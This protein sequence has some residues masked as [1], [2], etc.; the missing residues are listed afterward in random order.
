VRR[1]ARELL[2]LGEVAVALVLLVGAG[3]VIRTL[4]RLEDV[5]PGFAADR[6]VAMEVALPT[7][8]YPE[9]SQVPFYARLERRV[10]ALPGVVEVGA[11]N[12]L[13]LSDNYDSRGVQIEDAPQ[14]VGR[15]PSIQARSVTPGYFAAMG[16]PLLRGRLFDHTDRDD[17]RL[18][19]VVS[20]SMAV[21][22]W[23]DRDPIG[24]RVTFNAGVAD[25]GRQDVGGAGSREV[26]GVVGD[27]KHLALD[28]PAVPVFYTP[29]SQQPSYHTMTLVVRTAVE[30]D[31]LSRSLRAAL[32]EMDRDVP[33]SRPRTLEQIV[34]TSIAGPRVRAVLLGIFAGLALVL[35]SV[36]VY[37]VVGCLVV[38]RTH[39]IGIR[40]ALGAPTRRVLGLLV[41]DGMRPVCL[42]IVL[43]LGSAIALSRLLSAMVYGVTVTDAFVYASACA[44]LAVSGLVAAVV[45]ARRALA[46]DPMLGLNS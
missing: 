10:R 38:Q 19:I 1:G 16:V 25:A 13:P 11:V 22:Y 30:A 43:G 5:N 42:G 46:A 39:E 7:A 12:I 40:L 32:D 3:L 21:R 24:R 45:P 26:I 44:V 33:L 41:R 29:H 15:N 14:T 20:E 4:W 35:A 18:V 37:G 36:G 2:I 6:A 31:G 28:E 23:P 27:V 9:G 17:S 34:A 8:R